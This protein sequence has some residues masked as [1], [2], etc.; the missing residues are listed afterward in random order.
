MNTDTDTDII[1]TVNVTP[2]LGD[3]AL[4]ERYCL[5][6]RYDNTNYDDPIVTSHS[7]ERDDD[8]RFTKIEMT[9]ADGL[10]TSDY[11]LTKVVAVEVRA[12]DRSSQYDTAKKER[13]LCG[14]KTRAGGS[15]RRLVDPDV[16][17]CK[18][19]LY[20]EP[21]WHEVVRSELRVYVD[22]DVKSLAKGQAFEDL[23]TWQ[24]AMKDSWE[25]GRMEGFYDD[26]DPGTFMAYA[27]EVI[28]KAGGY[29]ALVTSGGRG[30]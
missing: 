13:V 9:R 12:E 30:L 28:E 23:G 16:G 6:V 24:S 19:H 4:P 5:W 21:E 7:I 8:G 14:S 11:D 10:P 17:H 1:E 22:L 29:E 25:D 3:D 27:A 15:C 18:P 20:E 26:V 2:D